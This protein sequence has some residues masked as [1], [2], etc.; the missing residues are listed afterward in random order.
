MWRGAPCLWAARG[1]PS[2]A[3]HG[4]CSACMAMLSGLRCCHERLSRVCLF[5]GV[6]GRQRGRCGRRAGASAGGA[7]RAAQAQVRLSPCSLPCTC[8]PRLLN[9]L[10]EP[11]GAEST[12][13]EVCRRPGACSACARRAGSSCKR[14][15][16][17]CTP[18]AANARRSPR[19]TTC[20]ANA[21]AQPL[22]P[23]PRT[24]PSPSRWAPRR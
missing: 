7:G 4:R 22:R 14:S 17:R 3:S 12:V 21:A 20:C 1:R 19:R 13:G 23:R 6:S 24:M 11:M 9:L 5:I 2:Q 8:A 16:R 10:D 15:R 18:Q